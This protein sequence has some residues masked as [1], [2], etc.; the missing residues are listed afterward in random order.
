[1]EEYKKLSNEEDTVNEA[2]L[3]DIAVKYLRDMNELTRSDNIDSD[4]GENV[5]A[6]LNDKYNIIS[7]TRKKR[8]RIRIYHSNSNYLKEMEEFN[9]GLRKNKP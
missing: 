4:T 5:N 6:A 8:D 3:I 9:K 2:E 7:K 1:M